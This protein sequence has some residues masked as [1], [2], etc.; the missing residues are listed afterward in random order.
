MMDIS[1]ILAYLIVNAFHIFVFYLAFCAFLCACRFR[2]SVE[3]ICFC[4]FY[5]INSIVF[6][7]F[8]NP[9]LNMATSILPLVAI[10]FLYQSP[11][12]EK[13]LLSFFIYGASMFLESISLSFLQLINFGR[14]FQVEIVVNMMA[15]ML[16]FSMILIYR[17][18][19]QKRIQK[20]L[21][22]EYW[23]AI[24]TLPIG[25]IVITILVYG[26]GGYRADSNLVIVTIIIGMNILVFRLYELLEQYYYS[27]YEKTLLQ[28]QNMAYAHE[29]EMIQ[30]ADEETRLLRHDLNNHFAVIRHLL[31]CRKFEELN[32]YLSILGDFRVKESHVF[33]G[34]SEID[35]ILNYK[36]S[37]AAALGAE[38]T[39]EIKIPTHMAIAP[40]DISI[41]L[42][43]LLDNACTA[44]EQ[45][46]DKRLKVNIYV[47][48][49]VLYIRIANPYSGDIKKLTNQG[50]TTYITQKEY[51]ALHGIG[52]TSVSNAIE[53]Y[54]GT[55]NIDD[56]AHEFTVDV[57]LYL[58]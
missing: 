13:L 50:I 21:K 7:L 51:K 31:D 35:S 38:I 11:V 52:L 41:I 9:F 19:H 44:I 45:C 39:T 2:P 17:R 24:L 42:G 3:L 26:G 10:T 36:L 56:A 4:T 1:S 22:F 5:L 58:P 28:Q 32:D 12:R 6:I 43:N 16:L 33:S 15:N 46:A 14:E 8:E 34:N 27:S 25:S 37:N 30:E 47:D 54:N 23:L 49:G 55:I 18:C 53:K 57:M 40:F 48:R 20:M 29:F